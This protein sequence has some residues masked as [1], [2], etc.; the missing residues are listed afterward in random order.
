MQWDV[1][2]LGSGAA[3]LTAALRAAKAGAKTLVLE[4]ADYY[5]GTT[6]ISGGGI[7]I[8]GSPQ[9]VAQGASDSIA[10]AREYALAAVGEDAPVPLIDAYLE[11]GPAM[12]TWLEAHSEVT[13]LL[14]PPSSDW[15]PDLPG[16]AFEHRLLSPRE[17][18]GKRL[19]AGF[20]E[21][22][23]AREEFNAP[24]GFMID[25][26]DLPYLA[27]MGAPRSILHFARLGARFALDK[28]RGYKRGTRLTMGN[29][30]AAALLKSAI[31]AGVTLRRNVTVTGLLREAGRITGVS[32]AGGEQLHASLGVLLATGGFSANP[33]LRKAYIPYAEQHVS[34]LPYENTGDGM[35]LAF[36][37]GAAAAPKNPVNAVWAV[38]STNKRADGSLARY[39]HLMDMSKPGCIAVN[40]KGE[41]FGNEASVH[42]VEAMHSAGAVPAYIIADALTVKKYGLGLVYPGSPNLK[43]LIRAGYVTEA[44]SL[45]ELAGKIGVDPA[46]LSRTAATMNDYAAT[47]TD[48]EFGKGDTLIDREIG[49]P[50]HAP[51]P[52]L[53]RIATAPFY[54]VK[55]LPGDGST[56][57]GLPIDSACRVLDA[58][59]VPLLGLY[60]AGLDAN[61][62]WRG[63]SPA[64]GC[65]VGPAMVLGFIAANAIL[66][67]G[68]HRAPI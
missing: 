10:R 19:G 38:V 21:L 66:Q 50:G 11:N 54:A 2:I 55:I 34:L 20:A 32:L 3:G 49:D 36:D 65:N 39:A 52:C 64:H 6:A 13:F 22:R 25:L 12:V 27:N 14:S 58:A 23:P 29:A 15:Y 5:G 1:I 40:A 16:A 30:L 56:T 45:A 4:K 44:A 63:R 28:L 35:N 46:G 7:W 57:V 61:S 67:A 37:N 18:D 43:K 33:Q 42:F 8:P 59:G 17:Y 51:N 31:D 53:G 26:F 24:G 41:R 9:A 48:P 60:A 47:G 62:I 68:E